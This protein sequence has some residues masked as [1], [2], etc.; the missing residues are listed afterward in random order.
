MLEEKGDIML[1]IAILGVGSRGATTYGDYLMTLKDKVKIT[2]ICD[3]DLNKL[4][5]YQKKYHLDASSCFSNTTDFFKAGKLADLLIIATLDQQHYEHAMQALDLDYHLLLEKPISPSIEECIEIEKKALE[6]KRIVVICHVLR[7]TAFYRKIKEI[8]DSKQLGDIVNINSVENV[9][10]WHQAHSFVRGNW[11]NSKETAPMILA[12]CCHDTDLLNWLIGKKPLYVSSYGSLSYFKK[13]NAPKG[14]AS[15][16]LDCQVRNQCPYDAIQYYVE[17]AKKVKQPRWPYDVVVLDPTPEK[18]LEA[19]K[20]SPYGRC[21]FNCDNDVV[22]HQVLNIQYEDQITVA[23]TM[24]AFSKECYRTLRVYGTM[25][26][27]I[28]N[29]LT[30]E[31]IVHPFKTGEEIVIDATKLTNDL[32]GHLGGDH[33]MLDELIN[34]LEGHPANLDSSIEKSVMSHLVCMAAEESRLHQGQS[35][36]IEEF[37]KQHS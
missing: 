21:V 26:D 10:Y 3:I 22:D 34:L 2:A 18:L 9:G 14:S 30:N 12:K 11:R 28:A 5:Y 33:V 24:C 6:K 1:K 7:Y 36:S 8:I 35:I 29:G 15:R 19:L 32:S 27:L 25:G 37:K 31:I 23:H 13:E 20:T 16:C 4:A 17:G